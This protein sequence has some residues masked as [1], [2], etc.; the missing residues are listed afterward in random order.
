[1]IFVV[2]GFAKGYQIAWSITACLTAF[3]MMDIKN[4]VLAFA[5]TM[6]ALVVIAEQDIFPYI[7]KI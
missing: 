5:M 1:M 3:N 7:P 4:F 2:A 6:L